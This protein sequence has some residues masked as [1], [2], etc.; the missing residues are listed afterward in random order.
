MPSGG[1]LTLAVDNTALPADGILLTLADTGVGIDPE[2]LP[3]V[4]EAFFTTRTT[5][6]TGIGLF[7]ARQFVQ[8]HGGSIDIT[9]STAPTTHG[10]TVHIF[11]PLHT[12]YDET[13]P[14]TPTTNPASS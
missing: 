14:P 4:F 7:V 13:T 12:A 3:R 11:L 1:T 10:T 6:G 5:V 8:G 2:N 9:T